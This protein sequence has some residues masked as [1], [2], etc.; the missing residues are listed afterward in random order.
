MQVPLQRVLILEVFGVHTDAM[1]LSGWTALHEAAAMG[2]VT[3]VEELLKAGATTNARCRGVTPLH[4]AVCAG[5]RQVFTRMFQTFFHSDW[6]GLGG[7]TVG[8]RCI[9]SSF[10]A[11]TGVF[12]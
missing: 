11:A 5:H 9:R 10:G 7:F 2:H 6:K 12:M 4:D 8:L 1:C 3:V